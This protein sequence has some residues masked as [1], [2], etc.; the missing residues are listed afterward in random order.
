MLIILL[1]QAKKVCLFEEK[2]LSEASNEHTKIAEESNQ[3]KLNNT[4]MSFYSIKNENDLLD[5]NDLMSIKTDLAGVKA[6]NT[7]NPIE[8]PIFFIGNFINFIL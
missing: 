6:A 4:D 3:S 8:N 1:S 7:N 5:R 2:I